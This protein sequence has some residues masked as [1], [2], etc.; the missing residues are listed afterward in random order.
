MMILY[1]YCGIFYLTNKIPNDITVDIFERKT[2]ANRMLHHDAKLI[3]LVVIRLSYHP[4]DVTG[5][6]RVSGAPL[7]LFRTHSL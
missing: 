2:L 3:I 7:K 5:E 1:P 6:R 4:C